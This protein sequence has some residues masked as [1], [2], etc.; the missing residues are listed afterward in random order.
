M[1]VKIEHRIGV[2]APAE[3]IWTV[4][5][6]IARWSE[7]NPIY[8][9]AEGALRIGATLTLELALDGRKPQVIRP[10]ILDWIPNEQIHWRLTALM[11]LVRTTRYLEIEALAD[12]ACIFANGELFEGPLGPTAARRMEGAIRAGFRAMGEAVKV[13]AEAAWRDGLS[14]PT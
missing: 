11:G 10:V 12:N 6:D 1:S 9:K 5:S 4:I 3:A 2:Q 7:W 14:A 8:P 13:R